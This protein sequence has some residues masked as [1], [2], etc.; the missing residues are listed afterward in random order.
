MR[1]YILLINSYTQSLGIILLYIGVQG[2]LITRTSQLRHVWLESR[3]RVYCGSAQATPCV[4]AQH[5]FIAPQ[6]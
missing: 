1:L 2:N 6:K 5:A 3:F 4:V